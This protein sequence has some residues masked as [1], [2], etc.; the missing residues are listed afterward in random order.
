MITIDDNG[1]PDPDTGADLDRNDPDTYDPLD[2]HAVGEM[3][4]PDN[5]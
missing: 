2:D 3:V 4:Q 1:T 5:G